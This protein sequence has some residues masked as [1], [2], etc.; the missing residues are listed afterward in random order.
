MLK[1]SSCILGALTL[2]LASFGEHAEAT[3]GCCCTDC[4]CLPGPQGPMGPQG[5]PGPQGSPGT[6]GIDGIRGPAGPTGSKGEQG[7]P[8]IPG[9]PG[10]NGA[11]GATG[12]AGPTGPKG[13]QGIQG[14]P[15]LPGAD[16]ANG[17][18]GPKGPAGPSGPTGAQGGQGMQGPMGPQ[19]PCCPRAGGVANVYSSL[20]QII[21]S[22]ESVLFENANAF[23]VGEFDLT[24]APTTGDITFLKSGV[25]VISWTIEGQL[26]PPYPDPVP[27]WSFALFLDSLP[28]PGSCFSGFNIFLEELTNMVSG[29][30]AI[31]ATA[32]QVLSLR[33]TSTLPVSVLS[34][35][36]GSLLPG[37]SASLLISRQ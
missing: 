24:M 20:D 27:G 33:S 1:K 26:L 23:T 15:G 31:T 11:N 2:I 18:P 22:G 9:P 5:A 10:S 13:E 19:G 29:G 32:G 6:N 34:S 35:T 3:D 25:Y 4:V 16:G 30:V 17:A 12:P 8:G 14:V 21:G 28:V 37:T 7:V 36:P